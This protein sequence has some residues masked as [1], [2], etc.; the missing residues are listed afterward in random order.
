MPFNEIQ[1]KT[2]Q[3]FEKPRYGLFEANAKALYL[4][5]GISVKGKKQEFHNLL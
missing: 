1:N 2:K 5:H 4:N 3:I